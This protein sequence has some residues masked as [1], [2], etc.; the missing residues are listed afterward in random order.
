MPKVKLTKPQ[1]ETLEE[2]VH[3]DG[4][5]VS[6]SYKP[7]QRLVDLGLITLSEQRFGGHYA[8][9]TDA[10]RRALAEAGDQR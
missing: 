10:G 8:R 7:A 4:L 2:I 3:R 5:S 1:L 6:A 9:P